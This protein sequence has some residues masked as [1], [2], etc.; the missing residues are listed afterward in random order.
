MSEVYEIVGNPLERTY[1]WYE[2]PMRQEGVVREGHGNRG[3]VSSGTYRQ[4]A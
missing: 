4:W 1:V 3:Y 2:R